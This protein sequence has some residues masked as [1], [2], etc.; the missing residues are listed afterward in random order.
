[1]AETLKNGLCK[2]KPLK[3]YDE[4]EESMNDRERFIEYICETM[5]RAKNSGSDFVASAI[6]ICTRKALLDKGLN[7]DNVSA[8]DELGILFDHNEARCTALMYA[9]LI[10]EPFEPLEKKTEEAEEG[11]EKET[12]KDKRDEPAIF[13]FNFM[14]REGPRKLALKFIES[15]REAGLSDEKILI[16]ASQ[17][18]AMA[19]EVG[20]VIEELQRIEKEQKEKEDG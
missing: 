3:I 12:E 20:D 9:A 8:H 5:K 6:Y 15:M 7:A 2:K 10:G 17:M 16:I 19:S 4:K 1:M 14:K 11:E 13:S 18:K